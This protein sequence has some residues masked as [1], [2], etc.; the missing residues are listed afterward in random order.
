MLSKCWFPR[1]ARGS[2]LTS[3]GESG[4]G[5]SSCTT[6]KLFHASPKT[7]KPLG[8]PSLVLL[9]PGCF[10]FLTQRPLTSWRWRVSLRPVQLLM[11]P[12]D[13]RVPSS[14]APGDNLSLRILPRESLSPFVGGLG[15]PSPSV[16]Q[17][18]ICEMTRSFLPTLRSWCPC[19]SSGTPPG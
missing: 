8:E 15:Q 11:S 13:P 10:C 1:R 7:R 12:Q 5:S 19:C 17:F 18:P 2:S 3:R 9:F 4:K 6:M 16:P 14:G